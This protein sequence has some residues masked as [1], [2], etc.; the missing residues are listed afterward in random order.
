MK[1]GELC[2][3]KE[4]FLSDATLNQAEGFCRRRLASVVI[5]KDF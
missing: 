1:I 2:T 4:A 3:N 5:R